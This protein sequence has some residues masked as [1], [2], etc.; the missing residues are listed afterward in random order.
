LGSKQPDWKYPSAQWIAGAEREA[1]TSGR[2]L[3]VL[4]GEALPKDNN[5]RLQLA[6]MCEERN[7][8]AAA[9]R[10]TAEALASDPKLGD[11]FQGRTRHQATG[12]AVLAGVGQGQDDP[13]P[14]EAARNR[15]RTQARDWF[16]ADLRLYA[17]T[18]ESGNTND[19]NAI[20]N[21]LQHWKVCPD[22]I[23]VRDPEA[24]Q[25]LPEAE[26]KE[27][28]ALWA[29]VEALLKRAQDGVK[30]DGKQ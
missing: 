28:Q 15:L 22:L 23:P 12:R 3:A 6:G 18:L 2:L 11:N 7:W 14:D 5:E 17:K 30:E 29:E 16:R 21:H 27:W 9:A 4:K 13:R 1:A 20:L 8:V 10:L 26:R 19:R 24:R 25:K